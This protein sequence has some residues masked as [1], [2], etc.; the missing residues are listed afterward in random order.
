MGEN[1]SRHPGAGSEK[2]VWGLNCVPTRRWSPDPRAWKLDLVWKQAFED[3]CG[4]VRASGGP[5]AT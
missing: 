4:E 2:G 5:S 3:D 1:T